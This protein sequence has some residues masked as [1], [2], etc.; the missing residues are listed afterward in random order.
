MRFIWQH[1][2]YA[3]LLRTI[4]IA[5]AVL[6]SD[7]YANGQQI[8]IVGSEL[9]VHTTKLTHA[10]RQYF[11]YSNT[12]LDMR[13]SPAKHVSADTLH[14]AMGQTALRTLLTINS[15]IP[16]LAVF[17][18]KAE[19]IDAT[20]T[21]SPA[22]TV[23]LSAIYMDPDPAL[24][25]KLIRLLLPKFSRVG[26][27]LGSSS[28][29]FASEITAAGQE[30]ALAITVQH[31]TG[32]DDIHPSLNKL[33]DVSAILA[34]P[35]PVIYNKSTLRSILQT[36]YRRGQPLIGY[37]SGMIKAGAL[38]TIICDGDQIA[39]QVQRMIS[40]YQQADKLSPPGYCDSIDLLVNT[41]V[42]K[43]LN[44]AVPPKEMLLRKL[45]Y[46]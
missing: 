5:L 45:Q 27:L 31:A 12:S 13:D 16:V 34:I 29:Q 15:A 33:T 36:M 24:Q 19:F 39:D 11:M 4:W 14:V 30:H 28:S 6:T 32:M 37:S 9:S 38:A 44:I 7:V 40:D 8:V 1:G 10:L 22:H 3:R 18:S 17:L 21:L 41:F 2:L 23:R 46:Q 26:V 20:A 43:S 35:D 42:Q 25:L